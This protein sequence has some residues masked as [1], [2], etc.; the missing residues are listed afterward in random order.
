MSLQELCHFACL[1]PKS[2]CIPNLTTN[3]VLQ[4]FAKSPSWY[5]VGGYGIWIIPVNQTEGLC[6]FSD[7]CNRQQCSFN[8]NVIVSMAH[9]FKSL[10][11]L[12][13]KIR[14]LVVRIPNSWRARNFYPNAP[15]GIQSHVGAMSGNY[16]YSHV[17]QHLL[18]KLPYPNY[19]AE[20][21]DSYARD[22][23]SHGSWR[24]NIS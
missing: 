11:T 16:S 24:S 23:V 12:L 4:T 2:T 5:G 19:S 3:S 1:W 10:I 17:F 21:L 8:L 13:P 20:L 7:I 14:L 9:P 6:V 22:I 18:Y 15:T